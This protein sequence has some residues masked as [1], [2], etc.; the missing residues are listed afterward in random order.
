MFKI[1]VVITIIQIKLG[2]LLSKS[3][4]RKLHSSLVKRILRNSKI[5]VKCVK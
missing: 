2:Y 5:Y 3:H 1:Q 4:K